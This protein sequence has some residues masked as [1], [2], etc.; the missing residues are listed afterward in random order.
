MG[1]RRFHFDRLEDASGISGCGRVAEGFLFT[2]TGEAV[3]HWLGKYGSINLYHS[4]DDVIQVHGHEGRT[5]LVFDDEPQS[6]TEN[7]K[8]EELKRDGN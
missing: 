7:V 8:K 1:L 6:S 2:D 4:I 3:V 5:L